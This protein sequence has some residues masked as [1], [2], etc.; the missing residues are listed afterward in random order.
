MP[1][2]YT[3]SATTIVITHEKLTTRVAGLGRAVEL[4]V[5]GL[6]AALHHV[7][8]ALRVRVAPPHLRRRA[9]WH[10]VMVQLMEGK[11]SLQKSVNNSQS[12]QILRIR[13]L[14]IAQFHGIRTSLEDS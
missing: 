13:P 6:H 9:A 12:T 7:E 8:A 4:A 1:C 2:T 10:L 11:T 5:E 14:V 3:I